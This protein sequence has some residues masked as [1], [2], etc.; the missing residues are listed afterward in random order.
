MFSRPTSI[1]RFL[2]EC[3]QRVPFFFGAGFFAGAFVVFAAV[4][5]AGFAAVVVVSVF[6]VLLTGV[7]T[8]GAVID[9][10]LFVEDVVAGAASTTGDTSVVGFGIGFAV[11]DT[12][13]ASIPS[14][15]PL[16][17]NSYAPFN[18]A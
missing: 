7:A 10:V 3:N 8:A 15:F 11:T 13:N 9:E 6:T 2:S 18:L 12:I 4:V 17:R 5:A 16:L 14:V 1:F